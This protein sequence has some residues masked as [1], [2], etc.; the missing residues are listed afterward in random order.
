[1]KNNLLGPKALKHVYDVLGLNTEMSFH[2]V[3]LSSVV[4]CQVNDDDRDK[5]IELQLPKSVRFVQMA[6]ENDGIKY[7][8]FGIV[9]FGLMDLQR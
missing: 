5:I 9:D 2:C 4:D 1:M 3:M 6:F 8:E 7:Y